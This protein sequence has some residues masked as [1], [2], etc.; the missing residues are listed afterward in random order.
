MNRKDPVFEI[1]SLLIVRPQLREERHST[2]GK[3]NM[4]LRWAAAI[5]AMIAPYAHYILGVAFLEV[6]VRNVTS[7][8]LFLALC[9]NIR[10]QMARRSTS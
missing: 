4:R 7:L 9:R 10:L 1:W 3:T 5:P 2:S 8:A 6:H